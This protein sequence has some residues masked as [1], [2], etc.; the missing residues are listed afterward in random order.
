LACSPENFP[1]NLNSAIGADQLTEKAG[2]AVSSENKRLDRKID[3][4][5][6]AVIYTEATFWITALF[7]L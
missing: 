3:P 1:V 4:I 7:P 5:H 2:D 6:G